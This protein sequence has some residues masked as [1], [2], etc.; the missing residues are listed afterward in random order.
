MSKEA[1]RIKRI[2]KVIDSLFDDYLEEF[3]TEHPIDN[4]FLTIYKDYKSIF[5]KE[6]AESAD[7]NIKDFL[8]YIYEN[9]DGILEY[10]ERMKK[11]THKIRIK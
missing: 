9:Q 7:E 10:R 2:E 4:S 3:R 6:A 11:I 1:K 8:Q 5:V